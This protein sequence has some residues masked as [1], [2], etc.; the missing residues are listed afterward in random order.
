MDERYVDTLYA[1]RLLY[2]II[3]APGLGLK[4]KN[5]SGCRFLFFYFFFVYPWCD[6]CL[7][8]RKPGA[9]LQAAGHDQILR[10]TYTFVGLFAV[11]GVS[12]YIRPRKQVN[13]RTRE[14][15]SV[16]R[17]HAQKGSRLSGHVCR[18]CD[19]IRFWDAAFI[20]GDVPFEG[21]STFCKKLPASNSCVCVACGAL[22]MHP[23]YMGVTFRTCVI[24]K[25]PP[26]ISFYVCSSISCTTQAQ[27]ESDYRT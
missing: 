13:T 3:P 9:P 7:G 14:Y 4:T 17:V 19:M 21:L 15:Q 8:R 25:E 1:I 5:W 16:V 26:G 6:V 12:Y 10:I 18:A 27:R 24:A 20:G 22:I 11:L 2:L 23:L